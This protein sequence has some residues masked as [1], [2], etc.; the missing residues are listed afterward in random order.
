MGALAI[1]VDRALGIP[2]L[3]ENYNTMRKSETKIYLKL[4]FVCYFFMGVETNPSSTILGTR[5]RKSKV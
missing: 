2:P 4:C 5:L 1:F 3:T